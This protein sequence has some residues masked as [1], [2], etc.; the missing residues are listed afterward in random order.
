MNKETALRLVL[1]LVGLSHLVLGLIA[2]VAPADL[3]T[4]IV[5]GFYGASLQ[6]TPQL[7]HVIRILG[8]FMIGIGMMA[9]WACRDPQRNQV[10]IIGIIAI[11]VLRVLQR[12]LLTQE[13]T[14]SF[15]LSSARI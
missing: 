9:M 12:L 2:N 7:H 5:S 10:V 4:K 6:I 3:L 8:V 15:N 13:I 1:A 14:S 11:L